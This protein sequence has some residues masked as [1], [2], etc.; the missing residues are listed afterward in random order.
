MHPSR[1]S[2]KRGAPRIRR[3][4]S[5]KS[6]GIL[7]KRLRRIS[8]HCP[9]L[10][11]VHLSPRKVRLNPPDIPISGWSTPRRGVSSIWIRNWSKL[12]NFDSSLRTFYF[13][14]KD[15]TSKIQDDAHHILIGIEHDGRVGNWKFTAWKLVDLYNFRVRLKAEFQ[16]SNRDLYQKELILD[17]GRSDEC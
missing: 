5:T 15:E 6:V 9:I 12:E 8:T 1:I 16:G 3:N 7:K 4:G 14:P 10:P 13:T 11:A 17:S 2:V